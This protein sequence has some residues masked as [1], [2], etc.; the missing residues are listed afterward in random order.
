MDAPCNLER[1]AAIYIDNFMST[2][3]DIGGNKEKPS[4]LYNGGSSS[5]IGANLQE[6]LHFRGNVS[7]G[8]GSK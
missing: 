5:Y 8:S 3:V 7:C 4:D 6:R 1:H 2:F